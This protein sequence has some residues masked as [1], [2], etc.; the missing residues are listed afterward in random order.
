MKFLSRKYQEVWSWALYDWA[1]SAFATTVMAGFF[2]VF[3]KKYWNDAVPVTVSTFR[4]SLISS[5]ASIVVALMSPVIGAIADQG[6]VRK[7]FLLFFATLGVVATGGLFFVQAGKWQIAA[8][9]YI[10]ALVGFSGG[11]VFYDSLLIDVTKGRKVDWVSSLGYSLGYLGGGLLFAVNVMMTLWPHAFGLKGSEEAVQISF[12]MV[13][14]WWGFFS[15]PLFLFVKEEGGRN[16][17]P[18]Y[19]EIAQGIHQLFETLRKIRLHQNAA[20][21][22][23]AYFF[24]IDGVYTVIRMAVDYGLS[25]GLEYQSLIVALLITQFVGFPFAIFFGKIGEKWGAK[26]GIY[27][28]LT[29]YLGVTVGSAFIQ[30]AWHFYV[31]AAMIGLAQG[32]VQA[33]SRSLFTRLVPDRQSGEFFGF[34]NMWGKYAAI[35]GPLLVGVVSFG[36]GEPRLSVL[37]IA[38][39]LLIGM[40]LLAKVRVAKSEA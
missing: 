33:L 32:G 39:L 35:L 17:S 5:I 10:F 1:N 3:F 26:L 18:S 40:I 21:F 31:L 30:K 38:L 28:S 12:L 20:I 13:A 7:K 4:L 29:C 24:Y 27:L 9:L 15:I 16:H 14:V 37:S 34:Y 6:G 25:I 8:F 36:T 22:L 23:I 11:N 19:K 2:P